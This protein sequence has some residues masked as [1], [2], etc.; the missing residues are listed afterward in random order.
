MDAR[1]KSLSAAVT[2]LREELTRGD[3]VNPDVM[4]GLFDLVLGAIGRR[5]VTMRADAQRPPMDVRIAR[6][7]AS[8][9]ERLSERWTIARMAKLAGM[10]R[11]AFIRL[12]TAT[13]GAPPLT[14][15]T[16]LRIEAAQA[17]L[18]ETDEAAAVIAERV[19]YGSVYAFSRAFSRLTGKPPVLFRRI[20]R[21]RS[22]P[23]MGRATMLRMAA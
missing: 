20:A 13:T 19:G 21:G 23:I 7:L 10:S 3:G 15:V 8:L 17:L 5:P 2:L 11:A 16:R 4:Q 9:R 12:F 1:D 18:A 14:Y 6:V 22:A